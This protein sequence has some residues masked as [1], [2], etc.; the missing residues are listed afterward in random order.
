MEIAKTSL[1]LTCS[2]GQWT[3]LFSGLI[4]HV[5]HSGK[6][7]HSDPEQGIYYRDGP[8]TVVGAGE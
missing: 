5:Y 8:C 4:N 2:T 6:Y 1:I 7:S 3:S